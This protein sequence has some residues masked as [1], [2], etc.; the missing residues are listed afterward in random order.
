MNSGVL[1]LG[2]YWW[3]KG[4]HCCV[5]P[6]LRT[7]LPQPVLQGPRGLPPQQPGEPVHQDLQTQDVRR[8]P[9]HLRVR[10]LPHWER[11]G[12]D[13]PRHAGW[14]EARDAP[15]K[16]FLSNQAGKGLE[17][18]TVVTPL[19][20]RGSGQTPPQTPA[21]HLR[22]VSM[23]VD[24]VWVNQCGCYCPSIEPRLIHVSWM[25]KAFFYYAFRPWTP[26]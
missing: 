3:S 11:A 24:L 26:F 9:L 16:M 2:A 14:V 12:D 10:H 4:Q 19:E 17:R 5:P 15:V 8:R 25:K 22:R 20:R 1:D 18:S 7:E 23:L 13:Q 21:H 6:H